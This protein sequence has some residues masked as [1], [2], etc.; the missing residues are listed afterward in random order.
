MDL[1]SSCDSRVF[2]RAPNQQMK[3]QHDLIRS[4]HISIHANLDIWSDQIMLAASPACMVHMIPFLL[5]R[6]GVSK[7]GRRPGIIG[8]EEEDLTIVSEI[9]RWPS[10]KAVREKLKTL[11]LSPSLVVYF[12]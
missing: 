4:Y 10:S 11:S 8:E 6:I 5:E 3:L 12:Q 1:P 9:Y 7:G 2:D